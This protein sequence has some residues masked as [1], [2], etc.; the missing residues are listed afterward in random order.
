MKKIYIF[1]VFFFSFSF[2][3]D[4]TTCYT[5]YYIIFP[6]VENCIT[7]S[8]GKITAN[9]YSTP[10][11]SLFRQVKYNG[12]SH[13]ANKNGIKSILF[14]FVQIEGAHKWIHTYKFTKDYIL[15]EKKEYKLTE[16]G[17]KYKKTIK[18]RIQNNGYLDPFTSSIYLYNQI[19]RKKDGILKIFYDGKGYNVPFK[20]LN[21]E[22]LKILKSKYDTIKVNLHPD[23]DTKGLLRPTGN[24]YL[25]VDK[26]L[27][28]PVK[29]ELEF[30]I[31]SFK[32][33]LNKIIWEEKHGN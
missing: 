19:F 8:N 26:N 33:I 10:L 15:F 22:K 31:G 32:L 12:Y 6:L 20:V 5:G 7:Y 4:L 3:R 29:M 17:Y 30:T 14:Y 25:W 27:K 16:K 24:W 21:E 23:F 13:Y 28:V 9:A 2:A 1:L 18:K 11:G